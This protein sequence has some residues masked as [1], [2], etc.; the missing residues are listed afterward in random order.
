MVVLLLCQ[1]LP[2]V[3]GQFCC[4]TDIYKGVRNGQEEGEGGKGE[5]REGG[6]RVRREGGKRGRR[7]GGKKGRKGE[8][9]SN[10]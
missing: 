9:D 7:E 10:F 3:S 2:A 1:L 8:R 4:N 5:R 6:K